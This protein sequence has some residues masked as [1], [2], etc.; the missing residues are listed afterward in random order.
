MFPQNTIC[1][2]L[3]WISFLQSIVFT[4]APD[5]KTVTYIYIYSQMKY[6]YQNERNKNSILIVYFLIQLKNSYNSEPN[7]NFPSFSV[8]LSFRLFYM[9]MC[10]CVYEF[11]EIIWKL[12]IKDDC[13][14]T[15]I[16]ISAILL[17]V[18][19]RLSAA[20]LLTWNQSQ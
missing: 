6:I 9:C 11:F 13:K 15:C 7:C 10:V 18:L 16:L 3:K 14:T 20:L 4:V 8:M 2:I 19:I 17:T 1:Q 12:V 5:Q